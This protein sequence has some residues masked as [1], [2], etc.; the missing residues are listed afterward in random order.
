[1]LSLEAAIRLA[2]EKSL[3]L[4]IVRRQLLATETD[5]IVER[6]AFDPSVS[7]DLSGGRTVDSSGETNTFYST[8]SLEQPVLTGGQFTLHFDNGWT[9]T[10]SGFSQLQSGTATPGVTVS[11]FYGSALGLTMTQPLLR[12]GGLA[13]NRT[14]MV[15]AANDAARSREAVV[16]QTLDL[17]ADVERAYWE[18]VRQRE[19]F[20]VTREA[21]RT[22]QILWDATRA[23]VEQGV[24]PPIDELVAESGAASRE[25]DV[26][27][28]ERAVWNAQD[29]LRRLFTPS[30]AMLTNESTLIPTDEP[31]LEPREIDLRALARAALTTRP[32]LTQ[33]KLELANRRLSLQLAQ[34]DRLPTLDLEGS[35]GMI[36]FGS[37]YLNDLTSGDLYEWS[38]GLVFSAPLGNRAAKA[39]ALKRQF[40][41][42]QAALTLKEEEQSIVLEVKE[43]ARGVLTD[44]KR[45]EVTQKARRLAEKKLEAEQMRFDLGLTTVQD[46][47]IFVRDFSE[48]QQAVVQ[49]LV[50]YRHSLIDLD[51]STG[52]LL[53]RHHIVPLADHEGP[54]S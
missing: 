11:R 44:V 28:A 42:E 29:R 10:T 37:H 41:M 5:P 14:P 43:A 53:N 15:I 9:K 21:L 51:R 52:Q 3:E 17:V 30:T 7:L 31:R 19:V 50:D 48:A 13:A 22:A 49:A 24:L 38:V 8:L 4:Q 54:S 27:I 12:G 23:K 32:E 2:L 20:R 1:M 18:L 6:A 26:V 33:A 36:G 35:A 40:E 34:N 25:E 39:T 16:E 45:V 46:V 47:L